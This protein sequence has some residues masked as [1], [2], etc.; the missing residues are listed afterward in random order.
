MNHLEFQLRSIHIIAVFSVVFA[1]L[2]IQ[3]CQAPNSREAETYYQSVDVVLEKFDRSL[4]VLIKKSAGL[5]QKSIIDTFNSGLDKISKDTA[6]ELS[7]VNPP[8][9]LLEAH[10]AA[11]SGWKIDFLTANY[12]CTGLHCYCLGESD[13]DQMFIEA[14]GA[15]SPSDRCDETLGF[16][17]CKCSAFLCC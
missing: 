11:L 15:P 16:P 6:K 14:C 17:I 13:C 8:P 10:S 3:G 9:S 12:H 5:P 2:L 4:D 7:K 1:G